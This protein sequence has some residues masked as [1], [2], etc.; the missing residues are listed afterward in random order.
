[1]V[2]VVIVGGGQAG[3]Q[4]ADTLS[5]G[6]PA[7]TITVLAAE[8][9]LPYQRPPLSK[10]FLAG[11]FPERRLYFRPDSFFEK[12]GID[13]RLDVTVVSIDPEAKSVQTQT[14]ETVP[15]DK[16]VIAT[17]ARIRPFPGADSLGL[18]YIRSID[19]GAAIAEK[20]AD[21][22]S[23][24]MIGG[25]FI[26][27]EA[28]AT[29][30]GLGKS[31]TVVEAM[32]MLMPNINAPAL[33]EF[34]HDHHLKQGVDILLG[35]TVSKIER[36]NS[37]YQVSL[38][39]GRALAADMIIAG[40]GVLPNAEIA[41]NA[42][43]ATSNGILV[44]EFCQTSNADIYAIG[45]CANGMHQLFKTHTRLESVQNAV[46]Q[47]K[48]A[49]DHILGDPKPYDALPWFW[50]DQYG[51]KLQMAGLSKGSDSYVI[52]GDMATDSFSICYFKKANLI[53][54]DSVSKPADHM[55]AKR[56]ISAG[57]SP[58]KDQCADDTTPLKVWLTE[59]LAC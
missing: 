28:A 30:K 54:V 39:D 57:I 56:L 24:L 45:D 33:S 48:C 31:V 26:G 25:G 34:Y 17:G 13:L 3:F 15:Y 32:D 6:D 9:H 8:P 59:T 53:A 10:K 46:D 43:L 11:E 37:G 19:D 36:L 51:L 12:R 55:A 50:S 5:K 4:A 22:D 49:A 44:N 58:S 2:T 23:V 14:G 52:R 41:V 21:L 38:S 35:L 29:L 20:A 40:I 1:M 42:G 18:D 27:L 47:A 7:L 16:L